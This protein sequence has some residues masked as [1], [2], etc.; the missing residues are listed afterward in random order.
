MKK[1]ENIIPE[2]ENNNRNLKNIVNTPSK[3]VERKNAH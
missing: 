2:E 1:E 3:D